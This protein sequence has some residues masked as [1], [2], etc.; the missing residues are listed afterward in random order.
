MVVN[1]IPAALP[2]RRVVA[3]KV[4]M[5]SEHGVRRRNTDTTITARA[6]LL[7]V[8]NIRSYT[9]RQFRSVGRYRYYH[10][11]L[12]HDRQQCWLELYDLRKI[13]YGQ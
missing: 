1:I 5:P 3:P 9:L 4:V 10:Q 8:G 11:D 6:A 2:L 12:P 7:R 13:F